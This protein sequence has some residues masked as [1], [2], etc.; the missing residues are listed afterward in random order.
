LNFFVLLFGLGI[1]FLAL[2]AGLA[3]FGE[4]MRMERA[5]F[6]LRAREKLVWPPSH[7]DETGPEWTNA[8]SKYPLAWENFI[9]SGSDSSPSLRVTLRDLFHP[10]PRKQVVGYFGALLIYLGAIALSEALLTLRIW[11][12]PFS[13]SDWVWKILAIVWSLAVTVVSTFWFGSLTRALLRWGRQT[14]ADEF[15][16]DQTLST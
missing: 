3:W 6:Y 8:I 16:D 7:S 2:A 14:A 13:G 11:S 4:L 12:E 15:L 10:E 5:G 9:A 1:P